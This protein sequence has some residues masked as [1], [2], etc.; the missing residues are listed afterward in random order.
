MGEVP[1]GAAGAGAGARGGECGGGFGAEGGGGIFLG[2]H[3]EGHAVVEELLLVWG[4]G[5]VGVGH[6]QG[7]A[8]VMSDVVVDGLV[9]EALDDFAQEIPGGVGGVAGGVAGDEARFGAGGADSGD[10]VVPGGVGPT[11]VHQAE[12]RGVGEDVAEG[13][14]VLVVLG[15]FGDEAGDGVVDVEEALFP[16]L[17]DGDGGEG[18]SGGEPED[19]GVGGHGLGGE[20][21][22]VGS[23]EAE[24]EVGDGLGVLG[25]VE[26]GADV[27]SGFDAGFDGGEGVVEVGHGEEG[28]RDK[29]R[30]TRGNSGDTGGYMGWRVLSLHFWSNHHVEHADHGGGFGSLGAV[31]GR[32]A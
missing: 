17:S 11:G 10:D 31:R 22:G 2:D 28:N 21:I 5:E 4:E 13:D 30:G 6:A 1:D 20:V 19:E 14:A 25:D 12:G 23:G 9:G 29:G 8:D 16:E 27:E 3:G 15:E 18:F 24:G 7:E 26:L 32:S